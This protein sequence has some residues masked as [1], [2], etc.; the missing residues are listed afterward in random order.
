MDFTTISNNNQ[1][2]EQILRY[3]FDIKQTMIQEINLDMIIQSIDNIEDLTGYKLFNKSELCKQLIEIP[4]ENLLLETKNL[5]CKNVIMQIDFNTIFKS[6]L[7]FT[8][9]F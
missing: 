1:E 3:I 2:N 6:K 4:N 9:I 5:I 8:F 7:N